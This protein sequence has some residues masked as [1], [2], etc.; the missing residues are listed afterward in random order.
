MIYAIVVIVA[1]AGLIARGVLLSRFVKR[2]EARRTLGPDGI[3][4]GGGPVE[5]AATAGA[6]WLLLLHG[7]GD[8][9]QTLEFLAHALAARGYGVF[10]PLLPGHGRALADFA[11]VSADALYE[12]TA[13][14]YR[15]LVARGDGPVGVVGLS[16]GG[17]LAVQLAAAEPD[18][19][20]LCLL[21]PYLAMPTGIQW[22]AR[23]S[24]VWGPLAPFVSAGGSRSILDP[25]AALENRAYGAFTPAAL[26]ALSDV[27]RRARAALPNV[28]APTLMIQS[29]SDNR[30]AASSAAAAF[31]RLGAHEKRLQWVTGA[32]HVITVDYGRELV[33]AAVGDWM[34]ARLPVNR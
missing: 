12:A 6:P 2:V 31:E 24:R 23:L 16:M 1:I 28:K 11:R 32:A 18:L 14:A 19:P 3:V 15:D 22:A 33:A 13:R 29:R 20:A 27:V 34:D 8:T 21:A 5:I 26:R 7:A 10:A 17:A 4:V 25:V 30:I 9:P